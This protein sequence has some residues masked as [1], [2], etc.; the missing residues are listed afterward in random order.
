MRDHGVPESDPQVQANGSIRIGGE[1]DKHLLD[2]ETLRKAI[3]ACKK[4]EVVLPPSVMAQ[5][6][7]GAREYA[8]CMRAHGVEN[9]PDPDANG[10][11][12]LPEEVPDNYDQARA[13]CIS[14]R[15]DSPSPGGTR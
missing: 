15:S 12:Q 3:D 8:R 14:G 2:D 9:F 13:A 11:F 4:Y 5:K 1:Y 10:R 6:I 7:E